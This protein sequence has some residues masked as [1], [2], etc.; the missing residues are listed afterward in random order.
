MLRLAD[1]GCL[2][3]IWHESQRD[4]A[5]IAARKGQALDHRRHDERVSFGDAALINCHWR[6]IRQ[7]HGPLSRCSSTSAIRDRRPA[8]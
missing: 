8:L 5:A 2:S 3:S 7:E 6:S 1:F 4:F